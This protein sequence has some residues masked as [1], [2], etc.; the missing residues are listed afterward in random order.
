MEH[1]LRLDDTPGGA[2]RFLA[3]TMLGRLATWLRILGYDVEYFRGADALL[4]ERAREEGRILLTRDSGLVR[5]RR[6]PP[7]L[8]VRSDHLPVQLRQVMQV[9]HLRPAAPSG[10]RCPRCNTVVERRSKAEVF[11]RVPEFVWSQQDAF[12]GCPSCGRVYWAGS[13]QRNMDEAIRALIG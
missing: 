11:G 13:H 12:W 5:R 1:E 10:R 4:I 3:D 7:H 9:F 6:L 8:F 2:P